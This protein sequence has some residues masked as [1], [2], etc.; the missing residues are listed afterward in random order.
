MSRSFVMKEDSSFKCLLVFQPS[1][2][3]WFVLIRKTL[4]LA[5]LRARLYTQVQASF[6]LQFP[7]DPAGTVHYI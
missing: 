7:R 3:F 5:L 6:L 1:E 2:F 4:A